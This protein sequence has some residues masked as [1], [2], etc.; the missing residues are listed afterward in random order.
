MALIWLLLCLLPA[1]AEP[2]ARARVDVGVLGTA[3]PGTGGDLDVLLGGRLE[4]GLSRTGAPLEAT[5]LLRGRTRI[6][7]L[8][9]PGPAATRVTQVGLRLVRQRVTVW[10]GR[11]P[12]AG[13]GWRLVDG[14]QV[15]AQ[16]ARGVSLGG[17][18]GLLPDPWSTA[19]S[20]DR[21]GAGPTLA[22]RSPRFRASVL[23]EVAASLAGPRPGLAPGSP[24]IDR[25]AA[26]ARL[27]GRPLTNLDL[28]ARVDI[29][30]RPGGAPSIADAG[31]DALWRFAPAWDLRAGWSVYSARVFLAT[32]ERDASLRTFAARRD[33]A[34][35]PPGGA[36]DALDSVHHHAWT[37]RVRRRPRAAP[38]PLGAELRL[39]YRHHPVAADRLAQAMLRVGAYGL[40]ER[41]DVE[42]Q[43]AFV[44]SDGRPRLE[45]GPRLF[46]DPDPQGVL[47]LEFAVLGL[48]DL[49]GAADP[50][51]AAVTESYVQVRPTPWLAVS[52]GYELEVARQGAPAHIGLAHAGWLRATVARR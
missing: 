30:A 22:Y 39:R 29:Q 41:A 34:L 33:P 37:V 49:S 38:D 1:H 45:G 36:T 4:Q 44:L 3:V 24:G 23:G 11:H 5:L 31:V 47:S 17:W 16:V 35:P 48:A 15:G 26:R 50:A 28:A 20:W 19:P 25:V 18:A 46:L 2:P 32:R 7:V 51:H 40:A 8:G 27:W 10:L 52:V 42:G 9:A 13:E 12:V 21:L 43:A 14:V 6:D